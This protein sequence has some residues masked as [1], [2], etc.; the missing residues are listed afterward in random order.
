MT[1]RRVAKNVRCFTFCN[2]KY[3]LTTSQPLNLVLPVSELVWRSLLAIW[4]APYPLAFR[5]TCLITSLGRLPPHPARPAVHL[6]LFPG[7]PCS[8][9]RSLRSCCRM[10]SIL[11]RAQPP[12]AI[13]IQFHTIPSPFAFPVP[14]LPSA[15]I[16]GVCE[17]TPYRLCVSSFTSLSQCDQA[18]VGDTTE[19]AHRSLNFLLLY[20]TTLLNTLGWGVEPNMM[21]IVG[22]GLRECSFAMV[23][24]LQMI[25]K[26]GH[27]KMREMPYFAQPTSAFAFACEIEGYSPIEATNLRK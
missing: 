19:R 2:C 14:S 21:V 10:F 20:R 7:L 8:F 25:D 3:T 12:F 16:S 15:H 27:G 11:L 17:C 5:P 4:R 9:P 13:L 6:R 24:V 26:G 23:Y 22:T 18:G 1:A